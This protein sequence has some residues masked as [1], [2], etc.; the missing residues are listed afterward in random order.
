MRTLKRLWVSFILR[1]DLG[2]GGFDP[3]LDLIH[4]GWNPKKQRETPRNYADNL[5]MGN[6]RMKIGEASAEWRVQ[7]R[8]GGTK[9]PATVTS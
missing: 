5:G 1:W 3:R 2:F 6:P 9:R 7:I 4:E 8:I